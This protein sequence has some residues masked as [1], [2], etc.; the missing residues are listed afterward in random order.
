M[1]FV[2]FSFADAG[3]AIRMAGAL[4]QSPGG[5]QWTREQP[6]PVGRRPAHNIL[7]HRSGITAYAAGRI[8]DEMSA[9]NLLFDTDMVDTMIAETN[10]EAERVKEAWTPTTRTEMASFI[11]LCILRGV[12][13]GHSESIDELWSA[14]HGRVIFAK[15]MS[16]TRFKD[17]RRF[18][19][20]D[21]RE[22]RNGRLMRDKLAAVRML[23]DGLVQNSQSCYIPTETVTV[24]EQLYPYRG[25][26]RYIQYIPSKPAKYGLKFWSL[27]DTVN[28]Y[29][30][31]FKM[32]TGRDEERELPLGEHVVLQLSEGL[33]GSGVG[34][35]VDNFFCSLPLARQLRQRDMTL[36]G[37][38]RS[39]RREVP[40]ELR[41]HRN[42]DL[43]S[44]EFVYTP[45]D[46]IQLCAYKAK[47]NKIVL[48]LSSQHS[49]PS[50]TAQENRKPTVIIDYNKSKGGT[51]SMDQQIGCYTV[52]YKSRRWHVVVFCNVL[53]IACLNAFILH[54]ESF[55]EWNANKSHR[56]RLFLVQLGQALCALNRQ[57]PIRREVAP[58]RA[59]PGKGRCH[60]CSRQEDRK[61]RSRCTVCNNF[62]CAQ[63]LQS[64]CIVCNPI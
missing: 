44:S 51:D 6:G 33:R 50:V 4:L 52:K 45:E 23:L 53:D 10:R 62:T 27:N 7:R 48:M 36:L 37:S 55:P 54:R 34:I 47:A 18:L 39:N 63:H 28:S 64:I 38:M 21:N 20:F 42:R 9:F 17:I 29:S 30:W 56:R 60:M 5:Q 2:A 43:Y 32:Y 8:A 15:T 40:I 14:E 22:T 11:G 24:D 57:D 12:Y 49:A 3:G 1:I 31:N 25:R 26:C 19:R 58:P 59:A 16:L 13:K 35:T 61:T 46:G 41:S